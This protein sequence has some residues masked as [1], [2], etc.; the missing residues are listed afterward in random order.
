MQLVTR[1]NRRPPS[2]SPALDV[3]T[4]VIGPGDTGIIIAMHEREEGGRE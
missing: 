3:M 4:I 1:T 2:L